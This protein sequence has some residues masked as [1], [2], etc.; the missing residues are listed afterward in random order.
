MH[1]MQ[2]WSLGWEDTLEKGENGN[3]LQHSCLENPMDKGAWGATVHGFPKRKEPGGYSPWV[4][5]ELDLTEWPNSN[6][7]ASVLGFS[8]SRSPLGR[9]F[10]LC[11]ILHAK[12]S[13]CVL[14]RCDSET[15]LF[16]S[17]FF[18]SVQLLSCVRLFAT[19][20][21]SACQVSLSFFFFLKYSP[22]LR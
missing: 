13:G 15:E 22:K 6:T 7:D 19:P 14:S 4:P 20:W 9:F 5:K 17:F 21:I 3:P 18:S 8:F 16:F 11:G 1:E 10:W 2:V 12:E